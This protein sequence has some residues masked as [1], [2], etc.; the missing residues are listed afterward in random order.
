MSWKDNGKNGKVP[1]V[2]IYIEDKELGK[3]IIIA[4]YKKSI[5]LPECYCEEM[6]GILYDF[7]RKSA[8]KFIGK[9]KKDY[10]NFVFYEK[11]INDK[12]FQIKP[13]KKREKKF[14]NKKRI[15]KRQMVRF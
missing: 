15:K 5:I 11:L 2:E 1:K 7:L 3:K 6:A 9:V 10:R 8:G 12:P 14:Y 13:E 4:Q